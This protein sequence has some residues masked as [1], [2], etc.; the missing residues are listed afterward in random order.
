M[1][2]YRCRGDRN[3]LAS[4]S[5]VH[6][7]KCVA[8]VAGAR[9]CT[10]CRGAV[11]CACLAHGSAV[12]C[13]RAAAPPPQ[14]VPTCRRSVTT[15]TCPRPRPSSSLTVIHTLRLSCPSRPSSALVLSR[16]RVSSYWQTA[17][18]AESRGSKVRGQT[19]LQTAHGRRDRVCAGVQ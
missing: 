19:R 1:R 7:R 16:H 6:L 8:A 3:A 10:R 13:R 15:S 4:D 14:S 11:W 12:S 18:I 9:A 5:A 2:N 17:Q